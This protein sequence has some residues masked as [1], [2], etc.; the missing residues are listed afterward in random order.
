[1]AEQSSPAQYGELSMNSQDI[2][3]NPLKSVRGRKAKTLVDLVQEGHPLSA[4]EEEAG[5]TLREIS[6]IPELGPRVQA[7]LQEFN[8][9]DSIGESVVKSRLYQ[10]LLN[11]EDEKTSVAAAGQLSKILG[12]ETPR[13]ASIGPM[14]QINIGKEEA[15]FLNSTRKYVDIK[16]EVVED[17]E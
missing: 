8:L 5:I 12:T 11:A 2:T 16:G 6:K 15:E 17:A 10:L 4:A 9:S 1:M 14:I 7:L 13:G 3:A